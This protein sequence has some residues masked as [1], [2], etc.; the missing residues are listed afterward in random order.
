[1]QDIIKNLKAELGSILEWYKSE[2]TTL[3][4]GRATPAIVEDLDVD[5]YGTRSPLKHIASISTPDPRTILI[6]PWDK[7]ALPAIQS[8]IESSSLNMNP[9]ADK[10]SIRLSLPPLTEERRKD[11]IKLLGAKTEEGR[12][13]SRHSRD[14]AV[15]KL[16]DMEKAKQISEDE[17]FRTKDSIQKEVDSFNDSIEK[18]RSEKEREI[19]EK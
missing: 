9:V 3:R 13:K 12:V 10:D 1:M 15:K 4:T 17:R 16:Q 2:I 18:I 11:M 5:M 6:S 8:A 19:M 14:E 7:G